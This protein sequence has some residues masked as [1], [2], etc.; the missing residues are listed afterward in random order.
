MGGRLGGDPMAEKLPVR[1]DGGWSCRENEGRTENS[2]G[3][4]DRPRISSDLV[5]VG[6][7][8]E[9]GGLADRKK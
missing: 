1:R 8:S 4:T 3:G 7:W 6:L 2:D 9:R 5:E